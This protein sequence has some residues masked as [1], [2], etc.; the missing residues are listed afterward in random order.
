[1]L[2]CDKDME[3]SMFEELDMRTGEIVGWCLYCLVNE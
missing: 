2:D 3:L 1:M